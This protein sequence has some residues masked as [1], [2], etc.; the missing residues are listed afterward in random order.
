[1][2]VQLEVVADRKIAD[3]FVT[4]KM[5][6]RVRPITI[7]RHDVEYSHSH[8]ADYLKYVEELILAMHSIN[9]AVN[10]N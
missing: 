10:I 1:M 5:R 4:S 9:R 2:E 6:S 8:A 7:E 3:L